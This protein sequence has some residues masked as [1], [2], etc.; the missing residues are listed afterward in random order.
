MIGELDRERHTKDGASKAP[1]AASTSTK[2]A[3]RPS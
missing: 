1:Q 3:S 2:T